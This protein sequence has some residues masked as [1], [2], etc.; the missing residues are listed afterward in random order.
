ME[1]RRARAGRRVRQILTHA[2]HAANPEQVHR[3]HLALDGRAAEGHERQPHHRA[4]D[5][6]RLVDRGR[7]LHPAVPPPV[8]VHARCV[9]GEI[10]PLAGGRDLEL[11]VA[12]R[13]RL[14][15]AP[16]ERFAHV[17]IPERHPFRRAIDRIRRI[18]VE[19]GV[20]A[21]EAQPEMRRRPQ[22]PRRGGERGGRR[23]AAP[24][25]IEGVGRG[26]AP[27]LRRGVCRERRRRGAIAGT[28]VHRGR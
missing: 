14:A 9:D 8:H 13:P 28:N 24:Q 10:A 16:H 22:Q 17:A 12:L 15:P 3:P 19:L 25:A 18:D 5:P 11:L 1:V 2:V 21:L 6:R 7:R 27:G 20:A 23:V 26:R 4:K